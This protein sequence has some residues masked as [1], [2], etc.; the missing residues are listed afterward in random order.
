[1]ASHILLCINFTDEPSIVRA[2]LERFSS[3]T[4]CETGRC[5]GIPTTGVNES[6]NEAL[7]E[8]T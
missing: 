3:K 7:T 6:I 5:G 2:L 1:M 4:G 8:I